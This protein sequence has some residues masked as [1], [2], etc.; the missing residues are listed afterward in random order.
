M[1]IGNVFII[2]SNK[3]VPLD[4]SFKIVFLVRE[5]GGANDIRGRSATSRS[6]DVNGDSSVGKRLFSMCFS[7]GGKDG[8]MFW[9]YIVLMVV[10]LVNSDSRKDET[11]PVLG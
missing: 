8:N 3:Q 2:F 7:L 6:A 10:S 1:D 4:R 5:G 11:R 9:P